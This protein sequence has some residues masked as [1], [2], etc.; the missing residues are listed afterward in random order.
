MIWVFPSVLQVSLILNPWSILV[1]SILAVTRYRQWCP[2]WSLF[3]LHL[4][5]Y[6]FLYL[7]ICLSILCIC[8]CTWSLEGSLRKSP[9]SPLWELWEWNSGHQVGSRIL[10]GWA[11]LA[12][13]QD[14]VLMGSL[15]AF[16]ECCRSLLLLILLWAPSVCPECSLYCDVMNRLGPGCIGRFPLETDHLLL[17]GLPSR[18]L[19]SGIL[20]VLISFLL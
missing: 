9:V 17:L 7:R 16:S 4:L 8:V 2:Q 20:Y 13:P 11:P 6:L 3:F 10:A 18:V 14:G 12:S 19:I 1:V 15:V 5:I